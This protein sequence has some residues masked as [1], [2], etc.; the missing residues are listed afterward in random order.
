MRRALS[1]S[2]SICP[3]LF[4]PS[5]L[6]FARLASK[7]RCADFL[8][9]GEATLQDEVRCEERFCEVVAE[10]LNQ[11]GDPGGTLNPHSWLGPG[12]ELAP[13]KLALIASALFLSFSRESNHSSIHVPSQLL[14]AGLNHDL[15]LTLVSY[16]GILLTLPW[17]LYF[18]GRPCCGWTKSCTTYETLEFSC[19]HQQTMVSHGFHLV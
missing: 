5:S 2:L 11:A 9:H 14:L 17:T 3:R 13:N 19:K 8:S 16:T 12:S 1:L 10:P 15:E 18:S 4:R 7:L 6:Q